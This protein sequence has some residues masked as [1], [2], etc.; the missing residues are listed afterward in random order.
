MEWWSPGAGERGMGYCLIST[1]CQV[2]KVLEMDGGGSFPMMSMYL[3][4]QNY[5]FK[6]G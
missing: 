5:T 3:I 1:I 6:N 4:P 2:G